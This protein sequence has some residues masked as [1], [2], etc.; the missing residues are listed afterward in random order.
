[1]R[2]T[3]VSQGMTVRNVCALGDDPYTRNQKNHARVFKCTVTGPAGSFTLTFRGETTLA[4]NTYDTAAQLKEKIEGIKTIDSVA[5]S[6]SSKTAGAICAPDGSNVVT[7]TFPF[8]DWRIPMD[9]P[10]F[11]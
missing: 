11:T 7:I 5:I 1:M 10:I 6:F 3:T 9:G 4:I 2:V 8:A